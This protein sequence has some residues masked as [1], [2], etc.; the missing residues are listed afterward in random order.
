MERFG[1]DGGALGLEVPCGFGRC[2]RVMRHNLRSL[3]LA[4]SSEGVQ[5]ES[6]CVGTFGCY[7]EET[8]VHDE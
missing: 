8:Q 1:T 6:A 4:A 3:A 5:R 2:I 7:L